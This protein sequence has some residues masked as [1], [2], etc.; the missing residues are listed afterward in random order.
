MTQQG[1]V[2]YRHIHHFT[3]ISCQYARTVCHNVAMDL[4]ISYDWNEDVQDD[5]T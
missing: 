2:T 5:L 3:I 4:Y 1:S